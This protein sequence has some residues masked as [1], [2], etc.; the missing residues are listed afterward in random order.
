MTPLQRKGMYALHASVL[1]SLLLWI[2]VGGNVTVGRFVYREGYMPGGGI[3]KRD[4]PIW[5]VRVT[6][7]D[8]FS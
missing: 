4:D 7:K 8:E 3:H 2:D 1:P 5:V 6:E